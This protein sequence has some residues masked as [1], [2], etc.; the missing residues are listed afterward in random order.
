MGSDFPP[1]DYAPPKGIQVSVSVTSPVEGERIFKALAEGGKVDLPFQKT[2]WSPGFGM[3]VDRFGTPW[4]VN[5]SSSLTAL[6]GPREGGV[7][8]C[9]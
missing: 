6:R 1:S 3:A 2:F 4:M 7:I 5:T 8:A 9:S